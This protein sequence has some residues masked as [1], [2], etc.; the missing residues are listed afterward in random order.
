MMGIGAAAPL[1]S[2][3]GAHLGLNTP[4]LLTAIPG[5]I[6]TVLALSFTENRVR[7]GQQKTSY[8]AIVSLSARSVLKQPHIVS[9]I[10]NSV[11]IATSAYFV[12]WLYQPMMMNLG[13]DNASFGFAH[14]FLVVCQMVIL[15][16]L[17]NLVSRSLNLYLILTGAV[18]AISLIIAA[19]L[20]SYWTLG[21]MLILA[22]GFGLT[23][24]EAI[25]AYINE[26]IDADNRATTNSLISMARRLTIALANPI[27]GSLSDHSISLSLVFVGLLAMAATAIFM[28][29]HK[30]K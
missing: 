9:I 19:I 26:F 11:L 12:I 7:D 16:K 29:F 4:M 22:G 5:L 17:Q 3:L 6:G 2:L 28:R 18:V 15:L 13:A 8:K 10:L 20:P 1:G 23:R 25:D 14:S 30:T 27:V 21:L 24:S